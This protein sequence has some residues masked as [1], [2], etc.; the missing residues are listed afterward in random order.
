MSASNHLHGKQFVQLY[1]G[2][3]GITPS[4]LDAHQM[5]P[6]WTTDYD[7]ARNF[8]GVDWE[9][10]EGTIVGAKVHKKHII[11][12]GSQEH[13]NIK[14]RWGIADSDEPLGRLEKEHTVRSGAPI[15]I[16]EITHIPNEG[17]SKVT[18]RSSM[19]VSQLRK[20]RA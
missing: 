6:H 13:D 12:V 5:G 9:D 15:H 19:S 10:T 7:V 11:P 2:L 4:T 18:D 16:T 8:A 20:F 14:D 1:R 17:S 3:E